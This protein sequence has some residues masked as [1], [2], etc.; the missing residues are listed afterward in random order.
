M[1]EQGSFGVFLE[2]GALRLPLCSALERA[3]TKQF[4][5]F[6]MAWVSLHTPWNLASFAMPEAVLRHSECISTFG[7]LRE[8]YLHHFVLHDAQSISHQHGDTFE[9]SFYH[10]CYHKCN[11]LL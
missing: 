2:S 11:L 8:I 3:S 6:A 10:L 9:G 7:Q 1:P 4:K 5:S